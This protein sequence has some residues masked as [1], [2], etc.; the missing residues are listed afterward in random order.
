MA[1]LDQNVS[2]KQWEDIIHHEK[3]VVL[4]QGHVLWVEKRW[5]DVQTMEVYIDDMLVKSL[6]AAWSYRPTGENL[7]DL[8]PTSYDVEPLQM[9]IQCVLWKVPQFPGNQARNRSQPWSNSS[10][11]DDEITQ[12]H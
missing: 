9:Y 5:G 10:P 8:A 2:L 6:K 3:K 4:L 11:L 7:Q 1:S 12:E